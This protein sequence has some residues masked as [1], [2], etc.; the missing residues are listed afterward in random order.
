MTVETLVRRRKWEKYDYGVIEIED[1]VIRLIVDITCD[2][3]WTHLLIRIF[4]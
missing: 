1:T 4:W 2:K 3:L